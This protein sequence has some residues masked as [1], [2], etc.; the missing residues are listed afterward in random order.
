MAAK[1]EGGGGG[2]GRLVSPFKGTG[3]ECDPDCRVY[4]NGVEIP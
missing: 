4:V 3:G 2:D 1:F